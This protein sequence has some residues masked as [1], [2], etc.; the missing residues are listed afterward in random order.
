MNSIIKRLSKYRFPFTISIA[1]AVIFIINV[2]TPLIADD[3]SNL[4]H[5]FYGDPNRVIRSFPDLIASTFNYYNSWGGRFFAQMLLTCMGFL[6]AA[7][8]DLLNTA[9]YLLC[10]WLIYDII[11]T[12]SGHHYVIYLSIHILLWI[13]VPDYG[14]VMFWNSGAANYL[15]MSIP[16][17]FVIRLFYRHLTAEAESIPE[18]TA[19]I[20]APKKTSSIP[21]VFGIPGCFL[22]GFLAGG[23][24]EQISAGMLVILTLCL[25]YERLHNIN[26]ELSS[27]SAYA[28]SLAGFCFLYFAPGNATRA[29][30][31]KAYPF[32]IKLGAIGYYLILFLWIPVVLMALGILFTERKHRPFLIQK[33]GI[34]LAGALASAGCLI[35]APSVP[36]RAFYIVCVYAILAAGTACRELIAHLVREHSA[37]VCAAC[38]GASLFVLAESADT[39]LASWEITSQ[40]RSREIYILEEREKGNLDL[41]VPIITHYY[42]LRAEHDALTGLSD[43]RENPDYWINRAVAE[44]YHLNSITGF[45]PAAD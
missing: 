33:S 1:A 40:T 34:F 31:D 18:K 38:L 45:Q 6:P 43:I 26:W 21:A 14:Q 7:A 23:S 12:G 15:Y 2:L 30:V 39:M 10:T 16:V 29:S 17:L 27:L 32:L 20:H 3:Y 42:P 11:R 13:C 9:A 8:T 44:H 36:E 35:A 22:L 28:G 4:A 37:M 24:M 41:Q 19:A 5:T 25:I